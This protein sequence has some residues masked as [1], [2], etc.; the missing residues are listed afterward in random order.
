MLQRI[1]QQRGYQG[2]KSVWYGFIVCAVL[3]VKLHGL[4][5]ITDHCIEALEYGNLSQT[6]VGTCIHKVWRLWFVYLLVFIIGAD[7]DLRNKV[8]IPLVFMLWNKIDTIKPTFWHFI[9]AFSINRNIKYIDTGTCGKS[10]FC[11]KINP[12]PRIW[13]VWPVSQPSGLPY[14]SKLRTQLFDWNSYSSPSASVTNVIIWMLLTFFRH[15]S[16]T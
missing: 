10:W 3:K 16:V 1:L 2:R 12:V 15:R 6:L 8:S 9:Q 14:C 13:S 7:D 4:Y 5:L 11:L